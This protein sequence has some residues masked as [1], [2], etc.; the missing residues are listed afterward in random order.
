MAREALAEPGVAP[1]ASSFVQT[2]KE[3]LS[4]LSLFDAARSRFFA[5]LNKF[6]ES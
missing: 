1:P 6:T 3:I 2:P 4:D 5:L